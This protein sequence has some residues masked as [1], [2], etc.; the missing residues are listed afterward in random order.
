MSQIGTG[1]ATPSL[2]FKVSNIIEATKRFGRG[3]KPRPASVRDE[4]VSCRRDIG[5]VSF[6]NLYSA[7]RNS[8][9]CPNIIERLCGAKSLSS[10]KE[11]LFPRAFII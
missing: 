1:F 3:C 9:N 6:E 11:I 7:T 5:C 4:A 8:F 2:T 10:I